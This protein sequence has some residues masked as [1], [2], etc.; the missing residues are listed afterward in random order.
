M[1]NELL[2]RLNMEARAI[3]KNI[4]TSPRKLRLVADVARKLT[5]LEA[6]EMLPYSQ[7]RAA[8]PLV[9]A[10]KSAVANAVSQGANPTD[11]SFKEIQIGEGPTLKRGRPVSRGMWHPI[12]KRTSRIRIIVTDEAR[13][14]KINAKLKRDVSSKSDKQVKQKTK[15]VKMSKK[16]VANKSK[17][18]NKNKKGDK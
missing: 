5:P 10:I 2:K 7:K 11:L 13:A 3:Q 14:Q 4:R 16:T 9:K 1:L 6:L 12:L 15:P 18:K 17:S 8:V